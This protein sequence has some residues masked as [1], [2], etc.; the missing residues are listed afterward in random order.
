MV[1]VARANA[2]ATNV[3]QHFYSVTDRRQA[4]RGAASC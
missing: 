1:E 3:E 2:T 4:A